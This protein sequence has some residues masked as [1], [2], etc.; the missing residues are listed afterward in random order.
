MTAYWDSVLAL[1]RLSADCLPKQMRFASSCLHGAPAGEPQTCARDALGTQAAPSG[2][3]QPAPPLQPQPWQRQASSAKAGEIAI[4]ENKTRMVGI[5]RM[6]KTPSLT[7]TTDNVHVL[8]S[9]GRGSLVA[10]GALTN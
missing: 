5:A 2:P 8:F 10:F 9:S 4:S 3:R 7:H 6:G 1:G